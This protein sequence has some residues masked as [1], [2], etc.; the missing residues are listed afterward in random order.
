MAVPARPPPI[1]VGTTPGASALTWTWTPC[2]LSAAVKSLTGV[3]MAPLRRAPHMRPETKAAR[4]CYLCTS[5]APIAVQGRTE[6]RTLIATGYRDARP[7]VFDRRCAEMPATHPGDTGPGRAPAQASRFT[8]LANLRLRTVRRRI[9]SMPGP[10]SKPRRTM[11]PACARNDS[12]AG[13]HAGCGTVGRQ[14]PSDRRTAT[15]TAC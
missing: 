10:A 15:R 14:S 4:C 11:Q 8:R 12:C 3:S 5:R 2:S 7:H 6:A 1:S 13:A 9:S